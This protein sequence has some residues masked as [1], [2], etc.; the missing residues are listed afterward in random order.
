MALDRGRAR[1]PRLRRESTFGRYSAYTPVTLPAG[2][3]AALE[4]PSGEGP[5]AVGTGPPS[6]QEQPAVLGPSESSAFW[7][8]Y[9]NVEP[10]EYELVW[11]EASGRCKWAPGPNSGWPSASGRENAARVVV[12]AGHVTSWTALE[13]PIDAAA[14]YADWAARTDAG[15]TSSL[16]AGM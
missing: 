5:F 15:T 14:W 4:P 7:G 2:A 6:F 16:D 11:N 9:V 12:R 1:A 10:G 8:L 3:I 13:C